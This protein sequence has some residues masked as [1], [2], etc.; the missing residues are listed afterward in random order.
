MAK[1]FKFRSRFVDFLVYVTFDMDAYRRGE[2]PSNQPTVLCDGKPTDVI[3]PAYK[4]WM[5]SVMS[6]IAKRI[7]EEIV[8]SLPI[9]LEPNRNT[10]ASNSEVWIYYPDGNYERAKEPPN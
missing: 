9:T 2:I 6:E 8:Y 1:V 5:H 4:A 7:D 3:L 10:P